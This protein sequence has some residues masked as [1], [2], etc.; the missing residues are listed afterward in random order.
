MRLCHGVFRPVQAV[1]NQLSKE[2]ISGHADGIQILFS[3]VIHHKYMTAAV[4]VRSQVYVLAD[5][6]KSFRSLDEHPSVAPGPQAVRCEPVQLEISGGSVLTGK[7]RVTEILQFRI[8][9][10]AEVGDPAC[11]H[12]S[13]FFTRVIQELFK[14]MAADIAEDA[15]V[16]FL[17]KEPGRPSRCAQSVRTESCHGNHFADVSALCNVSCQDR[18]FIMQ[19][20]RVIDHVLLAGCYYGFL[21]GIQLIQGCK[22]SLIRK[23]IFSGTH[24]PQAESTAFTGHCRAGDHMGFSVFQGFFLAP[25][26]FGLRKSLQESGNLLLVRII[27]ILQ[28]TAGFSQSVAHTVDMTVIQPYRGKHKFSRFYNRLRFPFRRIVHTVRYVHLFSPF[29]KLPKDSSPSRLSTDAVFS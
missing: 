14:L 25:G 29:R 8:F 5:F 11:G 13:F 1:Q 2:R 28:C 18:S 17:F 19:P 20:F 23:V 24:G 27:N 9:R 12:L 26:C 21:C 4:L 16:F 7:L 3:A 10:M 6:D 22:R 15:A